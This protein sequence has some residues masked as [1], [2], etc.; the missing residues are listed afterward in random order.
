MK[1]KSADIVASDIIKKNDK[2]K[3]YTLEEIRF[4][5]ALIAM[6]ADFCKTKIT[7]TLQSFHKD[8]PWSSSSVVSRLPG[9]TGS[10]LLKLFKGLNY[11]DYAML[12]FSLFNTLRKFKNFFKMRKK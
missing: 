3:G 9:K 12:G 11:V 5:R 4:Q 6:Q 2:F 7:K 8:A 1:E 10:I